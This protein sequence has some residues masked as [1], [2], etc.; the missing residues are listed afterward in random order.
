MYLGF[1]L[2]LLFD[3]RWD[4]WEYYVVMVPTVLLAQWK[5]NNQEK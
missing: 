2:S 1:T 4:K 5:V 3:A